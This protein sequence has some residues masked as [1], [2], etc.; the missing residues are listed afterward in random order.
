MYSER[1]RA[2]PKA[3]AVK[4]EIRAKLST[5]VTN[6]NNRIPISTFKRMKYAFAMWLSR[7]ERSTAN[8]LIN[9]ELWYDRLKRIEGHFGSAVG[10]Y[11]RFLRSLFILN[12]F[13]AV[14]SI[15]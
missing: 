3:I 12:G 2:L 10:T 4:R 6:K 1:L 5:L 9:I 15:G 11:F 7:T 14:I 8:R 13:I